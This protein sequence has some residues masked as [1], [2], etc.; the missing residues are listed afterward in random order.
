MGCLKLSLE[1]EVSVPGHSIY[2]KKCGNIGWK[3]KSYF[4]NMIF[5]NTEKTETRHVN[6]PQILFSARTTT[7]KS[8]KE[9]GFVFLL[10]KIVFI[11]SSVDWCARIRLN[12]LISLLEKESS[13][14]SSLKSH[15]QS[16]EYKD[17]AIMFSRR[18]NYG[19]LIQSKLV[20]SVNANNIGNCLW[21]VWFLLPNLLLSEDWRLEMKTLDCPETFFK[22]NFKESKYDASGHRFRNSLTNC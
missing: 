20:R 10:H 13:T 18:C 2:W 5:H 11:V 6:V 17:A 7:S 21:N 22:Q 12:V 16:I 9:A 19:E 15:E 8:L 3:T 14:G 1:A 4:S